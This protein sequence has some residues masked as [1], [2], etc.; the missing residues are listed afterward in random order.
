MA[1]KFDVSELTFETLDR[2]RGYLGWL[3][4]HDGSDLHIKANSQVRCRINGDIVPIDNAIMTKKDALVFAKEILR[5][6]FT[7]LVERK[8]VDLVFPYD[9]KVRFRVNIFFQMDGVSAVFRMIPIN[10]ISMDELKMPSPVK[11]LVEMDRGLVLVVGVTGSG[12]STTL[13]AMINEINKNSRRHILTIEDPIE[14]VHKDNKSIVNQRSIGQDTHSFANALK[15]SLR[16]DPDIILVGE[17]RDAET[18]NIALHAAETGHLVFSTLHTV[19]AKETINRIIATFDKEEQNRIRLTLSSVLRGILAQRLVPT[20]DGKRTAAI[21]V[22]LN[23][24]RISTLIMDNRDN[25]ILE[26]VEDGK[27][28]YGMQSFDQALLELYQRGFISEQEALNYATSRSDLKL[29]ISGVSGDI[30]IKRGISQDKDEKIF[31][32]DEIYALKV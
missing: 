1:E 14:F 15:A 29:K 9:N 16:E 22:L 4:K 6:R 8:E 3:L 28:I 13:A 20:V 10:I 12:K 19:D 5:N 26:S 32:E 31:E 11:K 23:T 27:E 24:P 30:D 2:V 18:I 7:E 21:E 25:E 17:M